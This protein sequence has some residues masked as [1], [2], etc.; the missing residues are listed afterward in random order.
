MIGD[1]QES[2]Q[3]ITCMTSS[4]IF[5]AH[6]VGDAS[7]FT[8][9]KPEHVAEKTKRTD[10]ILLLTHSLS[11][12]HAHVGITCNESS[13]VGSFAQWQCW[14]PFA[15]AKIGSSRVGNLVVAIV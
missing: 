3:E 8:R 12:T 14:P 10:S 6:G 4:A 15:V 7:R 11:L 5:I 9:P 1:F 13:T 2:N